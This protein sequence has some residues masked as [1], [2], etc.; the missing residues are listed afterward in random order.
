MQVAF[1]NSY[2]VLYGALG[3]VPITLLWI[4]ILWTLIFLGFQ[5][6]YCSQNF[7]Q[8]KL[9]MLYEADN[10]AE[11]DPWIFLGPYAPIEVIAA[12]VRKLENGQTPVPA[13]ALALSCQYPI[14]AIDA[15]LARLVQKNFVN[16]IEND[17]ELC[18][19]LSHP[20]DGLNLNKIQDV[21]DEST[22]RSSHYPNLQKLVHQLTDDRR[23]RLH[24]LNGHALRE[25]PFNLQ[26]DISDSYDTDISV[27]LENARMLLPDED[28]NLDSPADNSLTPEHDSEIP[29]T[30]TD[31]PLDEH[32]DNSLTPE[33]DSGIPQIETDCE[34]A[35][36]VS[37]DK[38]V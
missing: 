37:S 21:F 23:I 1:A 20:L 27:A 4:Y 30:E 35:S 18:Y 32:K 13:Y 29:Q 12:L 17:D 25:K 9:A 33:H 7:S 38:I 22:P 8:L 28:L 5:S 31:C 3:F 34:S 15:I 36:S 11:Q 6:C 19:I 26:K 24:N 2:R 16:V 10:N 14:Q